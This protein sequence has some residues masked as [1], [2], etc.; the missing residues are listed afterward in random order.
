MKTFISIIIAVAC[1]SLAVLAE[2]PDIDVR[3]DERGL[4]RCRGEFESGRIVASTVSAL[5]ENERP[6]YEI[7]FVRS[8]LAVPIVLSD[9]LWGFVEIADQNVEREWSAAERSFATA[10]AEMLGISMAL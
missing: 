9:G 8:V 6:A 4:Q 5:P 3:W 1:V 2:D 10:A 7:R